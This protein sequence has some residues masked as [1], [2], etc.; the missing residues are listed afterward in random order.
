MGLVGV[1]WFLSRSVSAVAARRVDRPEFLEIEFGDRL[2]LVGQS[3]TFEV[4]RQV[5]EPGAVFILQ[6]NQRR[7]RGFP[8]SGPWRETR[9]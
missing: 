9:G 8:T 4:V 3:R 1:K 6:S 7:H 5:V 2:E